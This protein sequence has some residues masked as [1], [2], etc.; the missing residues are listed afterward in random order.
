MSDTLQ[1]GEILTVEQL[2]E[3]TV[4]D[5]TQIIDMSFDDAERLIASARRIMGSE[6]TSRN[7]GCGARRARGRRRR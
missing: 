6:A 5:V 1:R 4:D 3:S 7:A 2:A